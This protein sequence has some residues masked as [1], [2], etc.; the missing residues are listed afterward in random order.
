MYF[1]EWGIRIDSDQSLYRCID[2]INLHNS[3]FR[4]ASKFLIA[5]TVFDYEGVLYITLGNGGDP[6]LSNAFLAANNNGL[7][8]YYSWNRPFWWNNES[9]KEIVWES[10]RSLPDNPEFPSIDIFDQ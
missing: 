8:I 7:E 4:D 1:S 6:M 2:L 9:V 3:S 5:Y 10:D